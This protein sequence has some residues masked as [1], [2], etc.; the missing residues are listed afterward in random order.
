ML[1]KYG[2]KV[3]YFIQLI[4]MICVVFYSFRHYLLLNE[5]VDIRKIFIGVLLFIL[6]IFLEFFLWAIVKGCN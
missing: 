1:L 4:L 3:F 2:F 5:Y 6:T